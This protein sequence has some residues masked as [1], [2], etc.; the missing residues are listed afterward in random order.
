MPIFSQKPTTAFKT[1]PT[2]STIWDTFR[3]GLN[4]LLASTE[5]NV[6]ELA[7]S[8]NIYLVGKGIPTKRGGIANYFLTA[9][10]VATDSQ[11][12]RGL[13]MVKF[14]SGASGVLELLALSDAG[15]LVRMNG[16]SYTILNGYSYVSGY[17]AQMVQTFNRV[18][19][20]NGQDG[21]TRYNGVS[22]ATF[23]SLSLPTEVTAT[24]VSG[25]SG[26]FTY[27]W[28]VSAENEIGE[29]L[30][31]NAIQL[32]NLPRDLT[33]TTVRVAWTTSSPASNVIR[34]N[35]YGRDAGY[36][37][38]LATVNPSSLIYL[39]SGKD[40]PTTLVLP[41]LSNETTGP[42]FK[43]EITN[44]DKLV[45]GNVNNAPSR[46]VWTGGGANNIERFH[47]SVGGG[48]V[49]ISP[50]DG[51]EVTGL[52]DAFDAIIIFKRRS[53]WKLTFSVSSQGVVIP[54]IFLLSR[55]VGCVAPKTVK[56]VE[57]DIFFLTD[58]GVYAL[59]QQAQYTSDLRT[60]EV[61]AKV[62]PNLQNMNREQITG[63]AAI[64]FD[65][66][67]RLSYPPGGSIIND[68]E[69]WFDRERG[70][71]IGPMNY[72]AS[73]QIYE[74]FI[75]G[76]NAQRLL[77]GD[78]KDN[79]VT[80][81]STGNSSD[82]GVTISSALL[83]KKELLGDPFLFKRITNIYSRWRNIRGTISVNVIVLTTTGQAITA[84]SFNVTAG[85]SGVGWGAD[86][87]GSE[88]W[89]NTIGAGSSSAAND[90]IRWTK[91][92]RTSRSIQWEI[93][94]SGANDQYQLLYLKMESR[95]LGRGIIPTTEKV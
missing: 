43:Y 47:W 14:A 57:N 38:L 49:D 87:W 37:T 95:L 15:Y 46:V 69:L 64:Y 82:K 32:A 56:Q 27:S 83:T 78:S 85:I 3:G 17:D 29:T 22:I 94:T 93:T 33:S 73:P 66:K 86:P 90:L 84:K 36:E 8:D 58:K 2:A 54:N 70:A 55:N 62:R 61:S 92:L 81:Y 6:N 18:Y 11:K 59:G 68:R 41:R 19:I 28:R 40:V 9:A 63:C 21:L 72:P 25:V 35:I 10:S 65:N 1:P 79:F 67:Y 45:G 75:D 71:W 44:K 26:T 51:D 91:L 7:Q 74:V 12:V 42:I 48:Y 5:I 31:S 20:A 50:N 13:K 34:Y 88:P 16:A 77:W 23:T 60:N 52:I 4:T 30:A 39:D 53:V 24:N 89:G 80:E 76:A